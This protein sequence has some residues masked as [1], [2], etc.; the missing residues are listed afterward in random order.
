MFSAHS[1]AADD[2]AYYQRLGMPRSKNARACFLWLGGFLTSVTVSLAGCNGR[3]D[4]LGA[5]I[6]QNGH[7]GVNIQKLE[8]EWLVFFQHYDLR[9]TG[10]TKRHGVQAAFCSGH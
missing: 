7:S 10:Y 5:F 6:D 2:M 8:A 9:M 4:E 1:N 3:Y